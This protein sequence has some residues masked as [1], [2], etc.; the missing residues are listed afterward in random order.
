MT[1]WGTLVQ[2]SWCWVTFKYSFLSRK[3]LRIILHTLLSFVFLKCLLISFDSDSAKCSYC[4]AISVSF[5]PQTYNLGKKY[6]DTS[7]I[8]WSIHQEMTKTSYW[9]CQRVIQC[10]YF[11]VYTWFEF[12]IFRVLFSVKD[13]LVSHLFNKPCWNNNSA[14]RFTVLLVIS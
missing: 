6:A 5:L 9:K 2:I 13:D 14:Y 1:N 3:P 4:H 11:T 7:A 8:Y 10:F 12:S